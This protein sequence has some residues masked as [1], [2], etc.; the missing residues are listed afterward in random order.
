MACVWLLAVKP[1]G[2][3]RGSDGLIAVLAIEGLLGVAFLA[4]LAAP[5]H[6]DLFRFLHFVAIIAPVL[7]AAVVVAAGVRLY[8]ASVAC[9][10]GVGVLSIP[11]M[12]PSPWI[13]APTDLV[14]TA[15]VV[16]VRWLLASNDG[17]EASPVVSLLGVQTDVD[18]VIGNSARKQREEI[19]NPI[20]VPDHF[21]FDA[22]GAIHL[23]NRELTVLAVSSREVSAYTGMW[24]TANRI[25][26]EDILRLSVDARAARIY[27]NQAIDFYLV[28]PDEA[29]DSDR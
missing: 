4:S 17:H 10:I 18:L 21:G 19:V 27:T 5:V 14:P 7:L 24:S 22:K 8:K 2:R 16:G 1:E 12:F 25:N 29:Y 6:L 28:Q 26:Q 3:L 9:V 23:G 15:E 13:K 20:P 11:F